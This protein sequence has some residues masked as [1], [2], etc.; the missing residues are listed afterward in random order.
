MQEVRQQEAEKREVAAKVKV[1]ELNN[2]EKLYMA[3]GKELADVRANL[4][5]KKGTLFIRLKSMSTNQSTASSYLS[6]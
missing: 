5:A 4:E 2:L 6:C 1:E 3:A